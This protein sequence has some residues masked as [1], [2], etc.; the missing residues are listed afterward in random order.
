MARDRATPIPIIASVS[1]SAS[2]PRDQMHALVDEARC[3]PTG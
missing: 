1:S 2:I 3:C